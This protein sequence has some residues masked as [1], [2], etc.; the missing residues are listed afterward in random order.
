[1]QFCSGLYWSFCYSRECWTPGDFCRTSPY[2]TSLTFF[3]LVFM[4]N[5]LYLHLTYLLIIIL[6]W[7]KHR[8]LLLSLSWQNKKRKRIREAFTHNARM[9]TIRSHSSSENEQAFYF[10]I[11]RPNCRRQ[12]KAYRSDHLATHRKDEGLL[13]TGFFVYTILGSTHSR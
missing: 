12:P 9:G 6:D 3:F 5:K 4:Q 1:M 13:A 2:D 11:M 7:Q 8:S 10:S